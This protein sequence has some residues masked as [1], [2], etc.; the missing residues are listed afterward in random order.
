[1]SLVIL[2][3]KNDDLNRDNL[4]KPDY[5][6]IRGRLALLGICRIDWLWLVLASLLRPAQDS[7]VETN[8][9]SGENRAAWHMEIALWLGLALLALGCGMLVWLVVVLQR[10][11]RRVA[12]PC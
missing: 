5:L 4:P 6:Y 2:L 3:S 8:D 9:P 10:A 12:Y 11:S 7:S 1:M